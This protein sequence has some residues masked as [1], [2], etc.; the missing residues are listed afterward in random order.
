[1]RSITILIRCCACTRNCV[2]A[3]PFLPAN[4]LCVD[5][6]IDYAARASV[7]GN[8][9][10]L[11]IPELLLF[12]QDGLKSIGGTR[13]MYHRSLVLSSVLALGIAAPASPAFAQQKSLKEQLIGT[14]TLVSWDGTRQDGTKY[15]DFGD[16]PKGVNTFDAND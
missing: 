16:N 8:G 5:I 13:T 9:P 7:S 4:G 6:M 12:L 10:L 3:R 2:P 15:S 14:W 11:F 1:M